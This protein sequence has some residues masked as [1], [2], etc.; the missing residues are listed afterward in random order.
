MRQFLVDEDFLKGLREYMDDHCE[1]GYV[2]TCDDILQQ[3]AGM[4]DLEARTVVAEMDGALT[5][6][7]IL[8][9]NIHEV[10]GE[11]AIKA[12]S[13]ALIGELEKRLRNVKKIGIK[14]TNPGEQ[15]NGH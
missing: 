2:A 8:I 14:H 15:D 7:N 11:K 10:A 1:H 13:W 4:T 12:N 5:G 3:P 6:L 9:D